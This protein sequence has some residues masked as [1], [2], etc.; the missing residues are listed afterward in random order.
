MKHGMLL[1][2]IYIF[3][4]NLNHH[5]C[6]E[7]PNK[8]MEIAVKESSNR[9]KYKIPLPSQPSPTNPVAAQGEV[10]VNLSVNSNGRTQ[11]IEFVEGSKQTFRTY[12]DFMKN[13]Q[14][15]PTLN[16]DNGPWL[17]RLYLTSSFTM[18]PGD[19]KYT[20]MQFK[21]LEVLDQK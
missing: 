1:I 10:I 12:N 2:C 17:V 19:R 20:K 7:D 9:I 14:F 4:M 13:L 11:K 18:L 21:I 3:G 5:L 6:A 8:S 16:S 15:T